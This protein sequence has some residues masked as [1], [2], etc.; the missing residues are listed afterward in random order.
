MRTLTLP[1]PQPKQEMFLRDHHK[2][3]IFGG[4]RGG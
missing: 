1:K 2:Y 4:A 3:V